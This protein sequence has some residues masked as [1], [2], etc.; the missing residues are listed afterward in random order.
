MEVSVNYLKRHKR[1]VGDF[2]R[3]CD[4]D[5]GFLGKEMDAIRRELGGV[6]E[7]DDWDEMEEGG[8][9]GEEE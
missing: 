2:L 7:G 3:L 6:V 1:P 5:V 9:G 8:E 4:S